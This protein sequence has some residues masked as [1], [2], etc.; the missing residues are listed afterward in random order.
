MG[1]PRQI[2]QRS[3]LYAK[4]VDKRGNVP[5]GKADSRDNEKVVSR[6][7]IAFFFVVLVGSSVVQIYNLFRSKPAL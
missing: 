4:N 1:A 6:G 5:I 7:L 3:D 2:R